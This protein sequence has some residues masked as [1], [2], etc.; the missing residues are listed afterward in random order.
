MKILFV[1]FP[2]PGH[3][4]PFIGI[5]QRMAEAGHAIA[6]YSQVDLS[7]RLT[8]AGLS[9]PAFHAPPTLCAP[10]RSPELR[11]KAFA[12]RLSKPAWARQ[13]YRFAL[14][15]NVPGQIENLRAAIREWQPD[16]VCSDPMAYAG[17]LAAELEG[18]PWAGVS[19]ML[20]PL[21]PDGWSCPFLDLVG[22]L[23]DEREALFESYGV[24]Q[25]FKHGDAI[26]PWL[27]TVFTTEELVPRDGA[28]N[29]FSHY[30]GPSAPLGRRGD[31][32]AF[33]WEQLAF[34]RPL[35]YVAFGSQ[36][37]PATQVMIDLA[38]ALAPDEAQVVIAFDDVDQEHVAWPEH[39]I[40]VPYAPQLAL[41]D[42]AAVMVSHGGA[43]SVAECLTRGKP[44]L[45]VPLAHDQPMQAH[46]L[47][48]SGAGATLAPTD[49]TP[50]RAR[51]SLVRLL[52]PAGP[53]RSRAR[54]IGESYAARLRADRVSELVLEL[55]RTRQPLAVA[56]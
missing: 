28:N 2:E 46:F 20:V 25:A 51:D 37:S 3:L 52:D 47:E 31:E 9:C 29:R 22:E 14:L 6:F 50:A 49:V 1:V 27:N 8:A 55:A 42:R 34:D 10:A 17:A 33:P 48:Q 35:V 21:A 45:I 30:V 32:P 11:R 7:A 54:E 12:E 40:V 56:P 43:N 26:S 4:H 24:R 38:S 15:G 53:A 19:T 44:M 13:W 5:A 16:A 41:L 39:A 23:A 18:V 36:L